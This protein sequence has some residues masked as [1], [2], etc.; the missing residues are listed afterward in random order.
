MMAGLL[1]WA[2]DRILE[3]FVEWLTESERRHVSG[4]TRELATGPVEVAVP[5]EHSGNDMDIPPLLSA[6]LALVVAGA[7]RQN[8]HFA[9]EESRVQR[10]GTTCLG[11]HSFLLVKFPAFAQVC[12]CSC[13]WLGSFWKTCRDIF[14]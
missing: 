1:S 2:Q 14:M 6:G 4:W 5:G 13:C 8:C 12:F 9:H 11:S 10:S 3:P 7:A